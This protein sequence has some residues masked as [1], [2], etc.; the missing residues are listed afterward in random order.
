MVHGGHGGAM[1]G[2]S[3][4]MSFHGGY[5]E[6]ILFEFWKIDSIGGLIGSMVGCF[7]LAVMYEGLKF[8][9]E[10]LFR[11]NLR[12]SGSQY[13]RPGS[14]STEGDENAPASADGS[15]Y[16]RRTL[17]NYLACNFALYLSVPVLVS[18]TTSSVRSADMSMWSCGHFILTL[19]HLVQVTLSY[20]L[21]LIFM[22][23][24]SWLCAA[25]VV[26]AAVGY[27]LFGWRK[28]IVYEES[29][30]FWLSVYSTCT[31]AIV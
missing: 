25:T 8:Y 23:Y 9:R 13:T 30:N 27:F 7:L 28:T 19:L 17:C 5:N 18:I 26:G 20:L 10:H 31:Y 11:K 24:N 4:S 22:T 16:I 2:M 14:Q 21:M 29:G 3:M 1:A 6:T 12:P 15:T